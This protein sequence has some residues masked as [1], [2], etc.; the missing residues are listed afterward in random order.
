MTRAR[1]APPPTAAVDRAAALLRAV[2]G[3]RFDDDNRDVVA[4][5]VARAARGWPGG[6]DA[7]VDAAAAGE[8]SA[9][10]ALF[11]A[12]T[13]GETYF[14]RHPE[15]FELVRRL[16]PR[17]AAGGL[18]RAWSAGCST[19]EEAWSLAF[20]LRDLV[21]APAVLAT[22]LNPAALA[23]AKAGRYGRWSLRGTGLPVEL[24]DASGK[25]EVPK[26]LRSLVRFA[27]LNLAADDWSAVLG[28]ARFEL[29]LCRNVL[30]Y[31]VPEVA[32]AVLR[33]LAGRLVDGGML[34]VSALDVELAPPALQP[35]VHDGVTVLE[36]RPTAA[37]PVPVTRVVE[38][39]KRAAAALP[40]H[41]AAIDAAR[42][43]ADRGDL[44]AA[45][46]AAEA[47]VAAERTPET[48]HLL[49]LVE[50]ELGHGA[51][52]VRLLQEAVAADPGYVL[53]HL[54]LGLNESLDAT[55]RAHHLDRALALV[56]GVPDER[57]LGGPDALPAAWVRKLASAA[58]RRHA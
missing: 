50:G 33:R 57:I 9:C 15:H 47:L 20:A 39:G 25:V 24:R 56:D 13:I 37:V 45:L 14:F 5:G 8:A 52:A 10:D 34:V 55:A 38:G 43:H 41:R 46:A 32:E 48:L 6:A 23:A 54:S 49:A 35:V 31:L 30:V 21:D 58:R 40:A 2:A 42:A 17:L 18:L 16:A 22:D 51:A 44:A 29:I 19:G 53:G 36:R 28:D 11:A 7:L 12:V 1:A 4:A 3:L 26:P 27:P